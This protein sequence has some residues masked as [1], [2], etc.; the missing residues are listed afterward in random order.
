[1]IA[2]SAQGTAAEPDMSSA[3]NPGMAVGLHVSVAGQLS[4]YGRDGA[5][6]RSQYRTRGG[7]QAAHASSGSAMLG[8][9]PPGVSARRGRCGA[10][11]AG[12]PRTMH[13]WLTGEA[14]SAAQAN[15]AAACG[16]AAGGSGADARHATTGGAVSCARRTG[17]GAAQSPQAVLGQKACSARAPGQ[18]PA[19]PD[20][21][22]TALAGQRRPQAEHHA[23]PEQGFC[24]LRPG[25]SAPGHTPNKHPGVR[26]RLG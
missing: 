12:A 21:P 20:P 22:A 16:V 25:T 17:S 9:A 6:G 19:R 14:S 13:S 2:G 18:L 10:P 15:A 4:R 3:Q 11:G 1:M 8:A 26:V 24:S 23:P 5:P 7:A